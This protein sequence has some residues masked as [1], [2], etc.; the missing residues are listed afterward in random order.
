VQKVKI[1]IVGLG[2]IGGFCAVLLKKA[3][4]EVFSNKN[5]KK[6]KLLLKL[7]SKYYGNLSASIK[8]DRTLNDVNI[9]LICS[10]FPYLR[11]NIKNIYN[12]KALVVPFLNGISHFHILKK[13]FKKRVYFSNIAKIIS[14][15]KSAN[16]ILH[17]SKNKPEVIISCENKDKNK[18]KIICNILKKIDFKLKVFDSDTKV[19]WTKLIRLSSISAMT[20]L[21]D[22]NLYEILN[23]K[24][25]MKQLESLVKEGLYLTKLLFN[26]KGSLNN[27]IKDIK[28]LPCNLT[29]S[30]QRDINSNTNTKS[31]IDTQIGA[32]YKLGVKSKLQLK[33]TNYIYMLLK[34]KMQKKH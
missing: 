15:K 4:Y 8:V 14:K 22:C 1:G 27:I 31:E 7:S 25:K 3:G 5:V 12:K 30:L 11:K 6:K 23:S 33:T 20:A 32:I 16:K 21:Y 13:K 2:G 19:I 24:N 26:F 9:I 18:I 28:K 17:L 10:K 29:T 34:K